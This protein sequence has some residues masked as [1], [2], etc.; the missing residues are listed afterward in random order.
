MLQQ[1]SILSSKYTFFVLTYMKKLLKHL[2]RD[3]AESLA[4]YTSLAKREKNIK[5]KEILESIALDEKKHYAML[6]EVT[7]IEIKARN[8]R[9][10]LYVF[11]SR[12]LW[13]TFWLK[14]MELGEVDAQ[15]QY[16]KISKKYPE[17]LKIIEDEE[18]HERELIDM[19]EEAKL[20]YLGSVVLGLND[21]LV[22]LT[23]ALA[24]FTF[25]IQ[26]SRTIALIWLITGISAS[27]SMAASEF[28]SQRRSRSKRGS[29]LFSLYGFRL[30]WDGNFSHSS[31]FS[32][33]KSILRTWMYSSHSTYYHRT[34]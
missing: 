11:L 6:R 19:L 3:E 32:H 15:V 13:L 25:A 7:E 9:V 29:Y 22:E 17:I 28:L 5:N 18:R 21:A 26:N 10:A 30:Y 1:K 33:I 2:Q 14:L 12:T 24:W 27:F 31:I 20:W 16:E 34:L 4:I 8:W 23:W